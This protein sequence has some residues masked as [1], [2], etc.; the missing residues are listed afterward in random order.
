MK[1]IKLTDTQIQDLLLALEYAEK[2]EKEHV[3]KLCKK[4]INTDLEI[5]PEDIL[6]RVLRLRTIIVTQLEIQ[7]LVNKCSHSGVFR[8]FICPKCNE[9]VK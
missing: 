8:G 4:S 3:N 1:T 9:Y 2:A 6:H 7:A 5:E